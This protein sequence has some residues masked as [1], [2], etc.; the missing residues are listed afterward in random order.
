MKDPNIFSSN[1]TG[2]NYFYFWP[3][4][5]I[6]FLSS[7]F[8]SNH[9][10]CKWAVV[11]HLNLCFFPRVD[12]SSKTKL[13]QIWGLFFHTRKSVHFYGLPKN[14]DQIQIGPSTVRL[15]LQMTSAVTGWHILPSA[16]HSSNKVEVC[17]CLSV[18]LSSIY[19]CL[20]IHLSILHSN[21]FWSFTKTCQA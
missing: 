6:F 9:G 18:C 11:Y 7:K 13:F 12:S 21:K 2:N 20:S 19:F 4:Q 3:H 15:F 8:K 14:A 10:V 17:L 16:C 1:I 5:P